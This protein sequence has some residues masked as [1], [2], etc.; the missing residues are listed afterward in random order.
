[1]HRMRSRGRRLTI[2]VTAALAV[3]APA[4]GRAQ[5]PPDSVALAWTDPGDDG[6]VGTAA[7]IDLRRSQAPITSA[8]WDQ[9]AVVGGVQAP[10]PAG[11]SEAFVVR[12]LTRG[13]PYYFALRV[14]DESGNWS[15]LSNVVLWDWSSDTTPPARPGGLAATAQG[16]I[17]HLIW[18]ANTEPDL[19]GY[20]IYRSSSAGGS[21]SQING[22]IVT[23]A[24]YNDASSG[25]GP[26]WYEVT[27][28]DQSGNESAASAPVSASTATTLTITMS[29]G[30]PNPSRMSDVVR[31]PVVLSMSGAGARLDIMD[32][33]GQTMRHIDLGSLG[34]GQQE[35]LWDGRNDAG[36]LVAPGVYSAMLSGHDLSG[37]VRLVRVP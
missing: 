32:A 33:A 26:A 11:T 16:G 17:V 12:G 30:Y 21:F 25:G 8:N 14:V 3:A 20:N 31:I 6:M 7:R 15:G 27:A 10:G 36:R 35:I 9:A 13:P 37:V 29:P 19:A 23:Q 5:A 18:T 4:R 28:L 1:M 24:T 22:A 34:A 2:L